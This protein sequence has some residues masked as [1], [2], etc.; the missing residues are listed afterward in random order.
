[1]GIE[2]M[3]EYDGERGDMKQRDGQSNESCGNSH[4]DKPGAD[5][6]DNCAD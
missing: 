6:V 3:I 4:G 2:R 1:M 5:K